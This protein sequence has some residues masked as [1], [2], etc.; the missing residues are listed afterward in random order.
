MH[1]NRLRTAV[2][3]ANY[4]NG[5]YFHEYWDGIV[6]QTVKPDYVVYVDDNSTDDSWEI[7]NKF[8]FGN[9][10]AM[11][12][13]RIGNIISGIRF[14][15]IRKAANGGP[16]SARNA[17]IMEVKDRVDVIFICDS[18]DV[19]YP[20]KIQKTLKVFEEYQHV[21]LVYSDYD[22]YNEK[23]GTLAREFKEVFSHNRLMQECIV[24]NNSA[25]PVGILKNI[26]MYDEDRNVISI[27]DYLHWC[28][29]ASIAAVHHIPE[30]LYKYRVH[31]TNLTVATPRDVLEQRHY[32]FRMKL[33][34]FLESGRNNG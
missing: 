3:T 26:G 2:I 4:N 20:T 32:N 5:K 31:T 23:T 34:Q 19:Y 27:E 9:T 13:N 8:V 16:A 30:A 6:K 25:F 7:V 24:S 14:I 10:E 28:K 11:S 1:K 15:A 21:G 29:I 33:K 22:V 18:D 17:G 12:H